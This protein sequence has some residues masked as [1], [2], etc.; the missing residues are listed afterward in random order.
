MINPL[1]GIQLNNQWFRYQEGSYKENINLKNSVKETQTSRTFDLQGASH[2]D[3]T[4]TLMLENTYQISVGSSDVGST[5]WLGV[6]RLYNL[7]SFMGTNGS[8]MPIIFV[9]PYGASFSVIPIGSLDIDELIAGSP[10]D[11]GVEFRV[12][13]TLSQI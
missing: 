10:Q 2:V 5:T 7:K 3:F 13:L 1:R 4:I 6:S 12:S 8:S 9:N 11:S